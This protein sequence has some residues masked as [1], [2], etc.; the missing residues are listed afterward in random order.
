VQPPPPG[1]AP[2]SACGRLVVPVQSSGG[3]SWWTSNDCGAHFSAETLILPNMVAGHSVAFMRTSL[4]PMSAM[5]GAG[6]IYLV[7][8]TRAFR[9][10]SV[11]STPNDI[12]ISVMPAPTA[13]IPN[14]AFGAPQRIPIEA[15]NTNANTNDHFIPGITADP[16]TSGS[17]AHL[18]LF[19]YNFPVAACAYA[20]PAN[21]AN[22]CNLR[23]GYVSSV[24][25]GTT[26][27]SPQ[28]LGSMPLSTIV[29]SSQGLMVGD[30]SQ[31]SVIPTGPYAGN[32]ISAFAVGLVDK[33]LN[34]AMYVPTHGLGILGGSAAT[35][36]GTSSEIARA[37]NEPYCNTEDEGA[38]G[39]TGDDNGDD[40]GD[41]TNGAEDGGGVCDNAGG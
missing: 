35:T 39:D 32:A 24:D 16:N 30:Y 3:V 1:S 10:G 7:W 31:G 8:Q 41:N 4:L 19:Y 15:D 25:G 23:V 36:S 21:P 29:H 22:Q 11:A 20:D 40:P 27:G 38:G 12:A 14:P 6:N 28:Y 37:S 18:G 17:S 33:T 13:A 5:D 34:Q 26:W 9:V 2:G